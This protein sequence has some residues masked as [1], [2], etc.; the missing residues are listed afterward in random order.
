MPLFPV[1][2]F[3][4]TIPTRGDYSKYTLPTGEVG[5]VEITWGDHLLAGVACSLDSVGYKALV[6]APAEVLGEAKPYAICG[7][8]P[9]VR[10]M[11]DEGFDLQIVGYGLSSVYHGDNEHCLLSDMVN[12]LKILSRVVKSVDEQ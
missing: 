6:A 1:S 10:E 5:K 7:S 3:A 2:L 9:L 8:L 11:K 12:A 4:D